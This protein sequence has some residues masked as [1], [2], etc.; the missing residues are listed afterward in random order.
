MAQIEVKLDS[1]K[2][3]LTWFNNTRIVSL[4]DKTVVVGTTPGVFFAL[5]NIASKF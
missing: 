3:F 5:G 4:E 2:L 1:R